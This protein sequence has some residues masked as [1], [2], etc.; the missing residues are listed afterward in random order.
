[1][2]TSSSAA[3]CER[4]EEKWNQACTMTAPPPLPAPQPHPLPESATEWPERRTE[5]EARVRSVGLGLLL[6][7][8]VTVVIFISRE[9]FDGLGLA[10]MVSFLILWM[11]SAWRL[12]SA[13]GPI[14]AWFS[15]LCAFKAFTRLLL[16]LDGRIP[17]VIATLT[18]GYAFYL[19]VQ[20]YRAG[21]F[22]PD[23]RKRAIRLGLPHPAGAPLV[24][25]IMAALM[26]WLFRHASL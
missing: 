2:C 16:R 9:A 4:N 15:G 10:A 5:I 18:F 14:A 25:F 24:I 22:D 11:I 23:Y 19:L 7:A 3:G 21:I 17:W 8:G 20:G 12:Q 1:M 6:F 26:G 13:L